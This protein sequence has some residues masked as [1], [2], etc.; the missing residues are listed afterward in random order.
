MM[1]QRMLR[2]KFVRTNVPERRCDI[3]VWIDATQMS[4][5]I[6]EEFSTGSQPQ[7]PPHPRVS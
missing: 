2:T 7:Y 1:K 5:G 3:I 4:Q 6:S